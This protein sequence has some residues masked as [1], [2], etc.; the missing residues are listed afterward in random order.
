MEILTNIHSIWRWAVLITAVGAVV[1]SVMAATGSRPWD[2]LSDRFSLFFTIAMDIQFLIGAVVWITGSR[3]NG[4]NAYLSFLH[5]ALMIA[6]IAL[7]HVGRS[8]ADR[9]KGDKVK[10]TQAAIFFG[11][12][13]VV[14]LIAIPLS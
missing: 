6:A 9:T 10:G 8:R 4:E 7:A 13:L 11:A 2:A 1:L 12:S 14:V 5:P 3:W